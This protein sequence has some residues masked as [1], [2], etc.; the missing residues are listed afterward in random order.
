[1]LAEPKSNWR[2]AS[3]FWEG[4]VYPISALRYAQLPNP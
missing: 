3:M 2:N 4:P 1:M